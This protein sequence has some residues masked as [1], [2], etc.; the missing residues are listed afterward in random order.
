MFCPL[1]RSKVWSWGF[2]LVFEGVLV[3]GCFEVGLV[4]FVVGLFWGI[5]LPKGFFSIQYGFL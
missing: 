5:L 2:G 1:R 3:W 4:G